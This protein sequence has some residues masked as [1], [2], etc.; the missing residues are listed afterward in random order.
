MKKEISKFSTYLGLVLLLGTLGL[1][2]TLM[3]TGNQSEPYTA[4]VLLLEGGHGKWDQG[5]LMFKEDGVVFESA[6]GKEHEEWSYDSLKKID[7]AKPRL[8]KITL[9]SGQHFNFTPFGGEIFDSN[10]VQFL[11]NQ[12]HSGVQI[13][14]ELG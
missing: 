11:H 13:K 6:S 3:A 14:S 4:K 8:L 1:A 7:V 12:V 5:R 9:L 2:S 10:L